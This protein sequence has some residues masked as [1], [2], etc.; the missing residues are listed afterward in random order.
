MTADTVL[1]DL[2]GTLIDS[3]YHCAL[4]WERAFARI[5]LQPPL[6]RVH[7][8]I[9][10]GGDKL[11]EHV[12]G[13]GA[14]VEREYGDELRE[15]WEQ[16]YG[17]LMSEVRAFDGA[18]EVVAMLRERGLRVALATSSESSLTERAL[19]ILG[20]TAEDFDAV[21][22]SSDADESKPSPDILVAALEAAGG[23]HAVLVG[24]ATWD[25]EAA[26]RIGMPTVCV[27]T[28][29]FGVEELQSTGAV[30]VVDAVGDL[31]DAD[32]DTILAADVPEGTD[33]AAEA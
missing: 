13:A 23:S 16:E 9:G 25:I 7:R 10:M 15:A 29:G 30:L 27:R 26:K 28:G 11:V 20:L 22:T 5:G 31:L 6:W 33:D 4:A 14:D 2:D 21:T 24:D 32:W 3:T 19:G 18:R 17:H 8:T 12:A 1:F